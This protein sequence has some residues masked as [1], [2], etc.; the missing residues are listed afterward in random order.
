MP[1]PVGAGLQPRL[2]DLL[3]PLQVPPRPQGP[4]WLLPSTSCMA[5]SVPPPATQ[6][7][8]PETESYRCF[9]LEGSVPKQGPTRTVLQPWLPLP[10]NNPECRTEMEPPVGGPGSR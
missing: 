6:S 5:V 8:W 3:H 7:P 2:L 4:S 10:G 9:S 1:G